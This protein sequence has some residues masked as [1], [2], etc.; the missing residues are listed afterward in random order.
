MS[1]SQPSSYM[2]PSHTCHYINEKIEKIGRMG[3]VPAWG[4][5]SNPACNARV[6][7][8]YKWEID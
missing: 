1:C 5:D 2:K 4:G 3:C 7:T 8:L 6:E